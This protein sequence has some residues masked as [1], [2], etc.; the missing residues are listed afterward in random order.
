MIPGADD[1]VRRIGRRDLLKGALTMAG[2]LL[3]A[4][5]FGLPETAFAEGFS[6]PPEHLGMLTDLTRCIGCRRCE[7]ACNKAND[8]PEPE[9][10][11]D[12]YS[13]F[14]EERRTDAQTYTVVNRYSNPS[15]LGEP[16]Y[17]K[18]QCMHCEEPACVSACL[19]AALKK[20]PEGP[21][22][23]DQNL[24]IG[25]RY[26]MAACPFSIPTYEYSSAF[27]P[28]VGKCFMCYDVRIAKGELPACAAECPMEAITFGKRSELLRLAS[29][30]ISSEP[31]EYIDHIY[32]EHEAGGTDWLYISGV[33]FGLL[34]FPMDLGLTPFPELTR[35]FLSMVPL[36]LVAWPALLGGIYL[37]S[38][39]RAQTAETEVAESE[40]GDDQ[41]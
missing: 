1:S 36:V 9:V 31:H 35:G 40:K 7:E 2:S 25:C 34:G 4:N 12:D 37:M 3:I 13:V 6:H 8:L 24:C 39:Q 11:F 23:Y 38:N 21:V 30:R 22:V 16:A 17:N 32:G 20:T 15:R 27:S 18:I 33:P 14:E 26:C 10:P 41:S 28:K 29:D 5:R 19:V